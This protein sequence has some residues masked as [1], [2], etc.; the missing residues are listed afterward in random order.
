MPNIEI[1]G[2]TA[3]YADIG[4]GKTLLMVH[5][6][7][8]H[9]GQWDT[10]REALGDGYRYL[11]PD[12]YD[13]GMTAPWPFDRDLNFDD[14]A[15]IVLAVMNAAAEPA[16]LVGHSYGGAVALRAAIRNQAMVRSLTLI[17]PGGCPLLAAAGRQ[18]EY[19]E[20]VRVMHAFLDAADSGDL[21]TA[22]RDFLNYYRCDPYAWDRLDPDTQSK[23]LSKTETQRQVYRAQM[24]N[25]TT[26][27]EL[28]ALQIET[29]VITG[30]ETTAPERGVCCVLDE[31]LPNARLHTIPDAG[32]AMPLTHPADVANALLKYIDTI[33]HELI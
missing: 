7:N 16:H 1:N 8:N 32:H 17:E 13:S 4:Q 18:R 2:V 11:L 23:V 10:V 3:H 28:H 33:E 26:L 6:A 30:G 21:V 31:H 9:G 12:L 14:E 5:A 24:S 20:Y 15:D 29:L 27:Q 22:W 25:P 19:D